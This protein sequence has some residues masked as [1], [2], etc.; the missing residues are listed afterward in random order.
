MNFKH[1]YICP[2][3]FSLLDVNS[4]SKTFPSRRNDK[5]VY[6]LCADT[7]DKTM[8]VN[9]QHNNVFSLSLV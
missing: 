3:A 7:I 4:Y 1:I 2:R 6:H 5:Y 9:I 8:L